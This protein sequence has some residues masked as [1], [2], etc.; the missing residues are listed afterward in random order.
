MK[1]RL[2]SIGLLFALMSAFVL[3]PA[4]SA[5]AKNDTNGKKAH[6][7]KGVKAKGKFGDATVNVTEFAVDSAGKL[8]AH[9]DVTSEKRGTL[10]T[11]RDAP[12]TVEVGR[13]A[14]AQQG[15]NSLGMLQQE[16]FCPILTLRL[17][18]ITLN[19]LGLVVQTSTINLVITAVPGDGNLLGNLLCAVAGLLNDNSALAQL[20]NQILALLGGIL[21]G[22]SPLTGAAPITITSFAM[23]GGQLV[24]NFFVNGANGQRFG[25]FVT[26]AQ[27]IEPPAGSCEILT[28]TLG[29]IDLNLL[30]LRVQL[31]GET[32]EDPI[33]ILIYAQPGPGNLLG[34]LL[35][36]LV[37]LLDDTATAARD[38]AIVS[39]LNRILKAAG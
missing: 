5:V 37:G 16:P 27:V 4:G 26:P 39:T 1:V 22:G 35:C 25:P 3:V 15:G 31:F 23:Q 11:F 30:G 20:L 18:P 13:A 10:G 32:P 19:L 21:S 9:G 12:V 8:V 24:A 33:T 6:P 29:P 7:F 28:L 34:N 38:R 17:A 36:G 14:N 2:T